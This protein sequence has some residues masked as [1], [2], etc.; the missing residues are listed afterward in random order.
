MSANLNQ[1]VWIYVERLY[2]HCYGTEEFKVFL[3]KFGVDYASLK[4]VNPKLIIQ[5]GPF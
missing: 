2:I 5:L 3:K 4:K 1:E